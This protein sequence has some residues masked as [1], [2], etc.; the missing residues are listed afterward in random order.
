MLQVLLSLLMILVLSVVGTIPETMAAKSKT[1]ATEAA[2]TGKHK[3]FSLKKHSAKKAADT[4]QSET[5]KHKNSSEEKNNE[6]P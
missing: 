5:T 4:A 1:T 6:K 3:K 2:T